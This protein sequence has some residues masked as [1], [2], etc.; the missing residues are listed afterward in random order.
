[1]CL[2]HC[3]YNM[4]GFPVQSLAA[5]D[6]ILHIQN[7]LWKPLLAAALCFNVLHELPEMAPVPDRKHL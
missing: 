7:V 5:I 3:A 6:L 2:G 4:H 1:M